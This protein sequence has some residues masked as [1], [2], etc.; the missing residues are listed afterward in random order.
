MR[1]VPHKQNVAQVLVGAKV[2]EASATIV[3]TNIILLAHTTFSALLWE[4]VLAL[5][6]MMR[7]T[8]IACVRWFNPYRNHDSRSLGE[9]ILH[10]RGLSDSFECVLIKQSISRAC[11]YLGIRDG[12]IR[13]DF[14]S[15]DDSP[16][17]LANIGDETLTTVLHLETSRKLR[18]IIFQIGIGKGLWTT[19]SAGC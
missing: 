9:R 10:R 15:D 14:R 18:L 1:V 4:V 7:L 16:A 19:M 3:L 12:S 13:F 11:R 6:L 5:V 8:L 17:C 2:S